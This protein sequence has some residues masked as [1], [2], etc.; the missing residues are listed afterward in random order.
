MKKSAAQTSIDLRDCQKNC[1]RNYK[2]TCKNRKF[3]SEK[4]VASD[5][6]ASVAAGAR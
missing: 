1:K 4:F 3:D 6:E 2:R 5:G